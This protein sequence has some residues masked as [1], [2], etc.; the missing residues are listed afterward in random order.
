M[1]TTIKYLRQGRGSA[2]NLEF[3]P[4]QSV[5]DETAARRRVGNYSSAYTIYQ[6][7]R[8]ASATLIIIVTARNIPLLPGQLITR[9]AG[10][11]IDSVNLHVLMAR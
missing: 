8:W 2:R 11:S 6:A 1:N 9:Q 7:P 4:R 5:R 10:K 3:V